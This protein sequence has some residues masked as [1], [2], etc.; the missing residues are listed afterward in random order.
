MTSGRQ[1]FCHLRREIS[2]LRFA[3]VEMTKW[4]VGVSVIC[5]FEMTVCRLPP[6]SSRAEGHGGMGIKTS[7]A[8]E[9][10]SRE[11]SGRYAAYHG[12]VRF[13]HF[14]SVEMTKWWIGVSV[15][16]PFEMTVCCLLPPSSRAE[17][18]GGMGIKISGAIE[19][20]S[21]E[22][23]FHYAAYHGRVGFLHSAPL[24]SK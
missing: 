10:L 19:T 9:T 22:I 21:R 13:L 23:S 20:L 11:I 12:R 14:A 2:P 7:G 6:P 8:I 16:C 24:R 15:I 4:P 3:S 18:H 17:G 5:P 1:R